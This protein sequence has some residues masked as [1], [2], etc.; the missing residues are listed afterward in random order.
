[1]R[2]TV[3]ED[4]GAHVPCSG[5]D[6]CLAT[7]DVPRGRWRACSMLGEQPLFGHSRRP[8]RTVARMFHARGT[9]IVWPQQ[10][11]LEDGGAHVP[12]SGNNHCLA[13][14]DVP[15]GRWRACSM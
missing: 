9:T 14:A 2:C 3:L 4:G 5:N 7:A 12:C 11:S 8:S 6:H 15:R 10:T 1:M 13:T